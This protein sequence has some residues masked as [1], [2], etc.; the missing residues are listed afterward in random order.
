[1]SIISNSCIKLNEFYFLDTDFQEWDS[2]MVRIT[3]C[4]IGITSIRLYKLLLRIQLHFPA[5][6]NFATVLLLVWSSN[7]LR[8]KS[9]QLQQ[10]I[11]H[12]A[13]EHARA[14]VR[15]SLSHPHRRHH[16]RS[17]PPCAPYNNCGQ[18]VGDYE[19]RDVVA[20]SSPTPQSTLPKNS[21][22]LRFYSTA[23]KFNSVN[24][25]QKQLQK[26]VEVLPL[27]ILFFTTY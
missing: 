13:V 12:Y 15:R 8:D 21:A 27:V 25:M 3:L 14:R 16:P 4:L 26:S 17:R 6:K 23:K 7:T 11:F 2:I 20:S 18:T 9:A 5:F 1:M 24:T 10:V 22:V 19:E